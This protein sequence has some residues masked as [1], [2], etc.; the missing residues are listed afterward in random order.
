MR[1]ILACL[2]RAAKFTL[3]RIVSVL[4]LRSAFRALH[5]LSLGGISRSEAALHRVSRFTVRCANFGDSRAANDE[6]YFTRRHSSVPF[7]KHPLEIT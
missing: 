5:C 2:M 3:I 6:Q 4:G 7:S 1:N